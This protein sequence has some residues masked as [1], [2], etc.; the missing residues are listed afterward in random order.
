MMGGFRVI[1]ENAND[2]QTRKGALLVRAHP[3]TKPETIPKWQ[4]YHL[5]SRR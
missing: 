1:R 2:E 4:K 3:T 5:L